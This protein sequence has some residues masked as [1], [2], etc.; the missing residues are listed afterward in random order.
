MSTVTLP[1]MNPG[2]KL[3]VHLNFFGQDNVNNPSQVVDTTTPIQVTGGAGLVTVAPVSG[4]NRAFDI[5]AVNPGSTQ[6]NADV[7][8]SPFL[9]PANRLTMN[10]TV[11]A[12]PPDTRRIDLGSTEFV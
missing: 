6:L 11:I 10:V 5:T 8:S 1:G 3:R 2:Q 7:A 12:P 9:T 4:D